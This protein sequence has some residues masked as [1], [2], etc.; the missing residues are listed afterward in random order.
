PAKVVEGY[1]QLSHSRAEDGA[2]VLGEDDAP[3]TLV[4]FEDFFCPHCQ[5]L[6]P[7]VTQLIEAYVATGAARYEFRF[8]ATAGGEQLNQ[9]ARLL[10]C[11]AAQRPAAFWEGHQLTYELMA[12]DD[13]PEDPAPLYADALDLDLD[14]LLACEPYAAQYITDAAYANELGVRGT[15]SIFIITADGEVYAAQTE[16]SFDALAR[17]IEQAKYGTPGGSEA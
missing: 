8:L 11:A 4:I 6:H 15:P 12:T 1:A 7:T 16:R 13:F 5:D 2:F 9:V 17:L 3:V 10:E 14:D